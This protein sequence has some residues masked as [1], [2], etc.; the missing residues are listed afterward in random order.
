MMI[1]DKLHTRIKGALALKGLS[2]SCIAKDLCVAPTTVSLVSRGYR[3]S[4]RIEQAI[5]DALGSTPA[6]LWPLRYV[7][8]ANE[9]ELP[10]SKT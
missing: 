3:R 5:A 9:K 8:Q 10:M 6:N 1:D 7:S 4:R 2:L